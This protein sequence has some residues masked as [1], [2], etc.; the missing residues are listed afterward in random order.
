MTTLAGSSTLAKRAPGSGIRILRRLLRHRLAV[1]GFVIITLFILLGAL[2]G[3]LTP[4]NP[5]EGDLRSSLEAPSTAHPFG[6]DEQGRD[7]LSRVL[8]GARLSLL[9][10]VASVLIASFAGVALGLISGYF[11]GWVDSV[12]MRVIDV[13]LTFPTILL[14]ILLVVVLGT[15]VLN[16]VIAV[17]IQAIPYFARLVRSVVL[18][19]REQ[20]YIQACHIVGCS[21]PR[22]L[23]LHVLPNAISPIIIQASFLVA[24]S[25][26]LSAGLSFL[27][28]GVPPPQPE[29]GAMMAAGRPYLAV[30]PY[31]VTLP[32]IALLL[33]VLGFNLCGDGLRDALDPRSVG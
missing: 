8:Y 10:G 23:F 21:L 33:V 15:S 11:G 6:T 1:V 4:Y 20:E 7:V 18:A 17:G 9:I 3:V 19:I 13:V 16:V 25:I 26:L 32:G 28:L 5:I 24:N 12:I 30:A 29:W 31:L 22:V 14:A 27:G 2:A